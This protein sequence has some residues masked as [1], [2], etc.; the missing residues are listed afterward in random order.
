MFRSNHFAIAASLL[1][2]APASAFAHAVLENPETAQNS[3]YKGVIAI[4]HGC[5][6]QATRALRVTIPEGF[7]AAKPMPKPGW[8]VTIDRGAYA[9]GYAYK[10]GTLAEGAK[11]LTW[12]GNLP[13]DEYDEFV[14]QGFVTDAVASGTTLYF[15]VDQDCGTSSYHWV[16]TPGETSAAT[17]AHPAPGVRITAAMPAENTVELVDHLRVSQPW[18]RASLDGEKT[19]RAYLEI[20]NRGAGSDRLV[21][22]TSDVASTIIISD[23]RTADQQGSGTPAPNGVS[24]APGERLSLRPGGYHLDLGGLKTPLKAGDSFMATITFEKAGTLAIRFQVEDS[25][26]VSS[27]TIM[28]VEDAPDRM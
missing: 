4:D 17:L 21:K 27:G 1:A 5:K 13:A 14:F 19:A 8:T 6:G 11:V 15:P 22:V 10:G 25:H 12:T 16:E 28:P 7:I 18:A 2:L 20:E 24:L 23:A 26:A 9:K 3:T